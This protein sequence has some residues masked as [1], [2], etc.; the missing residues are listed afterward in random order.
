MTSGA[1]VFVDVDTVVFAGEYDGSVVHEADVE[2][3]CVF[4]FGFE[5]CYYF[6]VLI[7]DG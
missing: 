7:E 1:V 5:S 4:Y 6:A 2:A 3:L